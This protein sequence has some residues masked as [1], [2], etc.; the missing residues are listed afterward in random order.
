MTTTTT[1]KRT[2]YTS[3]GIAMQPQAADSEGYLHYRDGF[4]E[5]VEE[6][7]WTAAEV[8]IAEADRRIERW[9]AGLV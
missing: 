5:E 6:S 9:R 1:T 4:M 7:A 3:M 2:H 8:V